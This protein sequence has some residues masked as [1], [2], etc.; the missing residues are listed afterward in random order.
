MAL[1]NLYTLSDD[2]LQNMFSVAVTQPTGLTPKVPG[3]IDL[4]VTEFQ[5]PEVSFGT[6]DVNYKTLKWTKPSGKTEFSNEFSFT[7]RIDRA[8]AW[9]KFF[10]DWNKAVLN[11]DTGDL[12]TDYGVEDG[13]TTNLR[14]LIKVYPA[15]DATGT[16]WAF[17]GC[18]PKTVPSIGF[19]QESGDA[20]TAEISFMCTRMT[21][22]A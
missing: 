3:E 15:W 10:E 6:Y 21:P 9:Y 14:T 2:A 12:G 1:T 22:L 4:R 17:H 19:S 8:Y 16:G 20:V 11:I 5:K 18:L 13:A 7:M